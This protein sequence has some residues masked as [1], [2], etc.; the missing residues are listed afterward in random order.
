M[1]EE[2]NRYTSQLKDVYDSCDATGTGYLDKEELTELCHK[3][4]LEREL[5]LL[6]ETLL[7]NN[8]FTRVNFEEFKEGFVTILSSTINLGLSDDESSYLEPVIPDGTKPKY[9]TEAK[10]YGCRTKPELESAILETPKYL[11]EEQRNTNVKSQLRRSTSLESVESL[12]SDEEAEN[13]KEEQQQIFEGQGQ[14]CTWD[15]NL[16]D[17]PREVSTLCLNTTENQIRVTCEDLGIGNNGYLNKQELYAVCKNIGLKEMEKEELEELFYKLDSDGDGRVS[18]KEFQHGLFSHIYIPCPF[19]STPLKSKRQRSHPNQILKD[20]GQQTA[21][22]SFLSNTAALNLFSS[23]NDGSGFAS[24]EQVVSI[25]AWEGVENCKEILKSLDFNVEERVNLLELSMILDDELIASKNGLQQAAVASYKHELHHLQTQVERIFSERNKA[26]ADLEKT[27]K[28]N[29]Q[30]FKE[31]DDNHSALEHHNESKLRALEQDFKGKLMTIKSEVKMEQELLMQ[32]MNHQRTR[33]EADFRYLQEEDCILRKKL[34]LMIKENSRLQNE[35]AEVVQK[36]SESENQVLKLQRDLNFILKDKLGL[37]D[38]YNTELFDQEARFAEIIQE[39]ELQCRRVKELH[40]KNDELQMEVEKLR[41]LLLHAKKA[42]LACCKMKTDNTGERPLPGNEKASIRDNIEKDD[43]FLGYQHLPATGQNDDTFITSEPYSVSIETELLV[44]ELKEQN[45]TMK[46]ELET[47]VNYYE[48]EIEL[49]KNNFEKE[50]KDIEQS[51]KIKISELEEQK[52]ALEE[53]NM[54]CHEV[55]DGL[56]SQ[57][58]KL[59]PI[60]EKRF[61][62]EKAEIEQC[63]AKEISNL[64]Q[65]LAQERERLEDDLKMKHVM[66]IHFMRKHIDE[67]KMEKEKMM[68]EIKESNDLNKRYK[69]DILQLNARTA[70]LNH[71]YVELSSKNKAGQKTTKILNQRFVELERQKEQEAMIAKQFRE[72]SVELKK[73]HFQQKLT[74]QGEKDMLDQDLKSVKEKLLEAN[75]RLNQAESQ[76]THE[77]QQLKTQMDNTVPKDLLVELETRLAEEQ[78]TVRKLQRD[79]DL[80]AEQMKWQLAI[81]QEEYENSHRLMEEKLGEVEMNLK[82]TQM[83]LQEKMSQLKEQFEKH[84]KSNLLLK[85]LYVKNAHLMKMLQ[86]TEQ[87]QKSTENR[88]LILEEKIS[89][90]NKLVGEI[91]FASL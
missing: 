58:Q 75:T 48:W 26:R 25:W 70:Q 13:S 9:I 50:R 90:L 22:P 66:E 63:Y 21:T 23:I 62:K 49:L 83:L 85:D 4:H 44:E 8:Q 5:P 1:G 45:Q 41:S 91:S 43:H 14:L 80:Q 74:W 32:Q 88:N 77:L 18:L 3:L 71:E 61:Q 55:I 29:W 59:D 38:P 7:G 68:Y 42:N 19:S 36:L 37:L 81:Y 86:V 17:N 73:E 69:E 40:D 34:T 20:N 35:V 33:L 64:G 57:V 54:K 30:L 6:L 79:L 28:R 46:T 11:Q 78:K 24:V 27:K 15:D 84:A 67:L 56:K 52:N 65:R 31:V 89:S 87:M 51:F 76:H 47:K 72:A 82:N 53:L 16:I 12:K 2:E 60:Q 39:Y 10:G